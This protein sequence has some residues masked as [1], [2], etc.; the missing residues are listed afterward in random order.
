MDILKHTNMTDAKPVNCP[1]APTT[2][3]SAYE[4]E[5][6]ADPTLYKSTLGALQYICI[7]RP[8]ILFCVNNLFSL[9]TNHQ[10]SIGKL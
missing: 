1:M 7:T 9:C 8:D 6:F 10:N 3:L 2:H 4:R 5:I